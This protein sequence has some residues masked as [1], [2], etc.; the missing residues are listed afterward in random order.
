MWEHCGSNFDV[1][2]FAGAEDRIGVM[3]YPVVGPD[4]VS[5]V[6]AHDV[7][8]DIEAR[9]V[10]REAESRAILERHLGDLS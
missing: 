3:H 7:W 9:A 4:F 1:L 6:E 8:S 10:A 2:S 5:G